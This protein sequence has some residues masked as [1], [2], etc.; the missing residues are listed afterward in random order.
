M[1]IYLKHPPLN[2]PQLIAAWPGMGYVAFRTVSFLIQELSAERFAHIEASDY[3]HASSVMVERSL[4]RIPPFPESN[5]YFWKNP[6]RASDLIFFLGDAQPAAELQMR[7]A[8]EVVAL[9]KELGVISVTTFAAAPA[10]I[11]HT[12]KPKVWGVATTRALRDSL[13]R[14]GVKLLRMGQVSG[15]NGLLLGVASLEALPGLC[16]LGEIPYYT[17]NLENPRAVMAVADVLERY[18]H[19]QFDYSPLAIEVERFDRDIAQMGKK[20]QETMSNFMNPEE[21]A[22]DFTPGGEEI[23]DMEE[24][25]REE[26][27]EEKKEQKGALAAPARLRIEE[28]FRLVK[29]DPAQAP[30]LKAELDKW[31][32]YAQFEDR[33]LDLFRKGKKTKGN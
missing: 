11:Q 25:F 18:L 2:R 32:V 19:L 13:P 7:M 8:K 12:Q 9:A 21:G 4:A 24:E 10:S 28:L 31:G 29:V 33:F 20:A 22:E 16:L 3:F 15:L 5:F 27:A 23:S 14:H 26:P 6:S 1:I 17:M 30:L